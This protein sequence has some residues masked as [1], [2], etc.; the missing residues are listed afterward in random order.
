MERGQAAP[1]GNGAAPGPSNGGSTPADVSDGEGTPVD[2]SDTE[3]G[4]AATPGGSSHRETPWQTPVKYAGKSSHRPGG[5]MKKVRPAV[6][7]VGRLSKML[8]VYRTVPQ[9]LTP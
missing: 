3:G 1:A 7:T 8:M 9:P 6:L 2:P 5:F 4:A